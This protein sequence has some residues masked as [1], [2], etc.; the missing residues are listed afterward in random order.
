MLLFM[1]LPTLNLV[2]INLSRILDRASEIGVRKAFGASS[3]TLIGQFIVENLVLTLLGSLAGL[4]LAS[5]VLS[6]LNSSG[7]LPYARLALNYRIFLY[8]LAMAVFFGIL[9]G[10]YPAWR[11]SKLHPVQA[12]RGR[13][14]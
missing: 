8:G 12:L 10:V 9:S 14:V 7:L 2:N 3:R 1:L 13:S 4:V 6:A 5:L 11:M